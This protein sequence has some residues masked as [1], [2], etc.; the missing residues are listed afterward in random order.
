MTI[1][2]TFPGDTIDMSN[3]ASRPAMASFNSILLLD[4][5]TMIAAAKFSRIQDV[6]RVIQGETGSLAE[7]DDMTTL[8]GMETS[9]QR[10]VTAVIGTGELIESA[11][12]DERRGGVAPM[13]QDAQPPIV[14]TPV[15]RTVPEVR[16]CLFGMMIEMANPS[17]ATPAA[18]ALPAAPPQ[19]TIALV[20]HENDANR[21]ILAIRQRFR[22]EVSSTSGTPW[23]EAFTLLGGIR[24]DEGLVVL[25]LTAKSGTID[26]LHMLNDRD[27]GFLAWQ[28]EDDDA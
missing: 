13:P 6:V 21:A 2:T 17:P 19:F 20:F 22:H 18:M 8:L 4:D 5:R 16:M 28:P 12:Q 10:F 7:N 1:W 26:W 15:P 25:H 14:A 27:F 23:S 3:P 9:R 11:P 24:S